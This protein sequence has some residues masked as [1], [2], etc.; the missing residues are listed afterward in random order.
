MQRFKF[1]L[2]YNGKH[3]FGWQKQPKQISIQEVIEF[4]LSKLFQDKIEVVGCGRTDTGVHAN[5]YVLHTDLPED[6]FSCQDLKYKLNKMLPESIAIYKVDKVASDFH[7]RFDATQ[8]TYR[9]FIHF[10]K[11]PFLTDKSLLINNQL[12]F[13]KMNVAAKKLI[14]KKDF[15]SFSKL[16]T[17][18]KTNICD[19]VDA[20]WIKADNESWYFEVLADRFLRNMVRAIVGT[21]LEV[22]EGKIAPEDIDTILELK[23]RSKAKKSVPA[24]ALFLWNIKYY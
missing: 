3:F 17:D 23:N 7:A 6:K 4:S 9:Y 19:L 20:K 12:D 16:H 5:Y 2:A 15:T 21:L 11:N 13:N 14:G 8:R 1:E 22:G 10:E 24:H 18:V